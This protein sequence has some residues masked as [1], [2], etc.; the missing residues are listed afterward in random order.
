MVKANQEKTDEEVMLLAD[1]KNYLDI[2]Y[3]DED[4]D[5][6]LLGIMRRGMERLDTIAGTTYDYSEEGARRGLLL[7]YCRY[8]MCNQTEAF[9]TNYGP[10]LLGLAMEGEV[11]V[12]AETEGY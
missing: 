5:K 7:D 10:E 8:A 11:S 6:K 1:V 4:T 3:E 2:T 12:Y 9:E